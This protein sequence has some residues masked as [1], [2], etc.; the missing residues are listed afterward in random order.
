MKVKEVYLPPQLTAVSFKAERGYALSDP[1][2]DQLNI[3]V[4]DDALVSQDSQNHVE[5]YE[6]G[7]N[8]TEGSNH[9]WD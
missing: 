2:M 3:W 5:V 1:L 7:N 4:C 6:T 9:F 8:W